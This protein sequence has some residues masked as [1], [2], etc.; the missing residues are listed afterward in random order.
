MKYHVIIT[1]SLCFSLFV[2]LMGC[3]VSPV[4][5]YNDNSYTFDLSEI[6]MAMRFTS[7]SNFFLI[8]SLF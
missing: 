2:M 1:L 7:L 8:V 3:D 4:K 6:E 5:H